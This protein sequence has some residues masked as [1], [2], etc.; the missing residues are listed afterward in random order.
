MI[1]DCCEPVPLPHY[2]KRHVPGQ[3][4][5]WKDE[6]RGR[7]PHLWAL[8]THFRPLDYTKSFLPWLHKWDTLKDAQV[9]TSQ[10]KK[11][12]WTQKRT[13]TTFKKNFDLEKQNQISVKL[14]RVFFFSVSSSG[15]LVVIKDYCQ[16]WRVSLMATPR[17][18]EVTVETELVRVERTRVVERERG[19]IW[20]WSLAAH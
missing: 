12:L 6:K 18:S 11:W 5:C 4:K 15:C 2:N 20:L 3:N 13:T 10:W 19:S 9:A 8:S 14:S 1:L 7:P 17:G 16:D